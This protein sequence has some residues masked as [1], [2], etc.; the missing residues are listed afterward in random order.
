MDTY[1]ETGTILAE[2]SGE[3]FSSFL[4]GF[5]KGFFENIKNVGLLIVFLNIV[6]KSFF[7]KRFINLIFFH[8]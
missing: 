1:K 4:S 8:Y 7:L 6:K 5:T 3:F 2:A